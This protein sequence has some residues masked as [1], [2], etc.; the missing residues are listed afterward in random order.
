[1]SQRR[2]APEQGSATLLDLRAFSVTLTRMLPA[3]LFSR[4]RDALLRWCKVRSWVDNAIDGE[5]CMDLALLSVAV[6]Y[7]KER[8]SHAAGR[9][10]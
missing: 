6:A 10:G 2:R 8:S 5:P 9:A 1:M 7:L 4:D 3:L